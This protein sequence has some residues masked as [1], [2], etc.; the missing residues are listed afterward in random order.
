MRI[1]EKTAFLYVGAHIG[2][3][4]SEETVGLEPMSRIRTD[5]L[6]WDRFLTAEWTQI[7]SDG[8]MAN[9]RERLG[10]VVQSNWQGMSRKEVLG[11]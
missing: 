10:S 9:V 7:P 4:L 5:V 2:F 11:L 8:Q 6:K 3:Y 1:S